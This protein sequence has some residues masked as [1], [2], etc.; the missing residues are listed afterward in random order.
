MAA[1]QKVKD[2]VCGMVIDP[3]KA[4]ATRV[5]E[6]TTYYFCSPG[7]AKDF[8]EDPENYINATA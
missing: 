5:H 4:S 1:T 8:E 2:V 7:C 6:G 3:N